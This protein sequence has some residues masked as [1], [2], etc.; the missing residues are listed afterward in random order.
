MVLKWFLFGY[1][2]QTVSNRSFKYDFRF[3]IFIFYK[4]LLFFSVNITIP[5]FVA[6]FYIINLLP[7]I[8]KSIQKVNSASTFKKERAKRITE[9]H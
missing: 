2:Q 8:K 9:I 5:V 7:T 6:C 4:F 3:N 1:L